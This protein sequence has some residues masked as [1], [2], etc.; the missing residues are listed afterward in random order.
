MMEFP[1]QL[2]KGQSIHSG[3]C[4]HHGYNNNGKTFLLFQYIIILENLQRWSHLEEE[5]VTR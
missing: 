2:R 5:T 3:L 4:T 1:N